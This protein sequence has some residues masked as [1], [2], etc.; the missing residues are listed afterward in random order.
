MFK[1]LLK[2]LAACDLIRQEPDGT[3]LHGMKG[4]KLV[5]HYDFYTAFVSP[6]E[7]R[8]VSAGRQLG[9]L[10]IVNPVTE[11]SFLI[12]AG[13]RWRIVTV[14]NEKHVIDLTPA[15]GG[16]V[17]VFDNGSRGAV[18]DRVRQEMLAVYT[19]DDV[20]TYLDKEA[21]DLLREA[22]KNFARYTL[23]RTNYIICGDGTLYFPWSGTLATNT[24]VQQLAGRDVVVSI[25]GPA[26]VAHG[27]APAALRD[28]VTAC[29]AERP[30]DTI[31]LAANVENKIDEK[32]DWALDETTLCASYASR[33]LERNPTLYPPR[34]LS[35]RSSATP[36]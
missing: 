30:I 29:E 4:E 9:T 3:L 28:A 22:R 14:D 27:I 8:L 32:W 36:R 33:K 6:D 31:A 26:I 5:N 19:T 18:H 13:R 21:A 23:D 15:A 20:P 10:P 2:E 1:P 34:D 24:L 25:E 17:P 16:R 7:Y 11:G 35:S 12:F